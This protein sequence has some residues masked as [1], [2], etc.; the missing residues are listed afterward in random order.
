MAEFPDV[1]SVSRRQDEHT[2]RRA[3]PASGEQPFPAPVPV[4]SRPAGVG[5]TT[6]EHRVLREAF[7]GRECGG[8]GATANQKTVA[9]HLSSE[10]HSKSTQGGATQCRET[11]FQG[12]CCIPL[13]WDLSSVFMIG[14]TDLSGNGRPTGNDDAE[15]AL[16]SHEGDDWVYVLNGGQGERA[17]FARPRK[18]RCQ[19]NDDPFSWRSKAATG[20]LVGWVTDAGFGQVSCGRARSSQSP[21]NAASRSGRSCMAAWPASSMTARVARG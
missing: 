19:N 4:A 14:R 8:R 16:H 20:D 9:R 15:P 18:Q 21:I 11:P 6:H 2:N 13:E 12:V 17:L 1:P 7:A 10:M 5:R 3:A